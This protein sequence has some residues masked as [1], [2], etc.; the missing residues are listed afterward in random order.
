MTL[1]FH[2]VQMD[3]MGWWWKG[4]NCYIW[5]NKHSDREEMIFLIMK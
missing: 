2:K 5:E 4:K 3:E 1:Y